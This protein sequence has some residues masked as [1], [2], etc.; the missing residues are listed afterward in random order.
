MIAMLG[1]TPSPGSVGTLAMPPSILIGFR[2]RLRE[3]SLG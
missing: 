3:I 2:A 1:S